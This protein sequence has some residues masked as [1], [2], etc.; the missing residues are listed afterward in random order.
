[1]KRAWWAVR[2]PAVTEG[3]SAPLDAQVPM[4]V[5]GATSRIARHEA[6]RRPW[7]MP[8]LRVLRNAL[9]AA[10]AM[11][12]VPLATAAVRG[13]H[14]AKILYDSRSN[15]RERVRVVAEP[16][17][18][19]GVARDPSITPM[20]AGIALNTLQYH[21]SETWQFVGIRPATHLGRPWRSQKLTPDMFESARPDLYDGPSSRTILEASVKGFT[22]REQAYLKALAEAPVWRTFDLVARAPAVDIVGG[23]FRLPFD[24]GAVA[25]QRPLPSYKESRELAFAAVSRAAYYMSIGRPREAEQTLRTVISFGFAL[26]DNGTT[27]LDELIGTVIVGTG[28]DALRRF[29]AIEHDPRA[30][31]PELAILTKGSFN[32]ASG[33]PRS[34]MTR[35]EVRRELL[36]RLADPTLPRPERFETVQALTMMQCTSAQE[37]LFGQPDDVRDAIVHA[38]STLA[39]Y[40]SERALIDLGTRLP[41]AALVSSS[42]SPVQSLLVSPAIVAG[43][44]L[45]NPRMGACT[46]MLTGW[47][48]SG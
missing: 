6:A 25:A 21:R 24:P 16:V 5:S 46:L 7:W 10:V 12:V 23:Q 28:R 30:T 48:G 2:E 27:T 13:D 20:Q 37:L 14:F 8:V 40:P 47:G 34:G 45:R 33:A 17:R 36:A 35:D 9:V 32:R 18:A 44:V 39:R 41:S 4:R 1:M 38:N 26:I 19:F 22:P 11:A 31:L 3:W 29:Y 42:A 43:A 15:V